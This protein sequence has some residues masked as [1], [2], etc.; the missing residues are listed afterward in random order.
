MAASRFDIDSG[1]DRLMLVSGQGHLIG[2]PSRPGSS[3][4]VT[5]GVPTN[6]IAGF[7][8]GAV[9]HNYKGSAGSALYV[10]IGTNLSA[11]WQN[12]V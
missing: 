9:F 8:P 4:A 6:G 3:S 5:T 12:V 11:T 2:L 10:N 7:A 1:V